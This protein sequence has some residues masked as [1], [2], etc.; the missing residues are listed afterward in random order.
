MVRKMLGYRDPGLNILAWSARISTES[1]CRWH[2]TEHR[3]VAH[4]K[5]LKFYVYVIAN[6]R[7]WYLDCHGI[8]AAIGELIEMSEDAADE[9][10]VFCKVF[11]NEYRVWA[12]LTISLP[13]ITVDTMPSWSWLRMRVLNDALRS[14]MYGI[15]ADFQCYGC[16]LQERRM[17][18]VILRVGASSG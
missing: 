3:K 6:L 13:S 1:W 4:R 2:F 12:I 18:A 15:R 9:S 8:R 10:L 11:I 17:T 16:Q 7:L 14:W 5:T